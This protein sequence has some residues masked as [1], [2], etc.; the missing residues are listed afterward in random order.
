MSKIKLLC[1]DVDG[2]LLRTDLSISNRTKEAIH[3][4]IESG[5]IFALVSGRS[6]QSL[7]V[8]QKRLDIDAPMGTLNG[9]VTLL[10]K[11]ELIEE[12]PIT[13][14]DLDTVMDDLS[15]TKLEYF[16]YTRSGWYAQEETRWFAFE[17]QLSGT[18]GNIVNLRELDAILHD[19]EPPI[20]FLTM[21]DDPQ[22]ILETTEMLHNHF[23]GRLAVTNSHPSYIEILALSVNKGRSVRALQRAYGLEDSEV[24]VVGDYFNDIPMFEAAGTAVVM[25]NAPDAVKKY[26]HRT[27]ASN[28]EDGLVRVIESLLQ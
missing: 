27:T 9:A 7:N 21:H 11:G 10:P 15:H 20:K 26:A 17:E 24:M 28:D 12:I 3:T 6:P 8:I 5:I 1:S 22:Y 14:E 16:I 13:F 25:E 2:T 4:L 19:K 23:D 18:R